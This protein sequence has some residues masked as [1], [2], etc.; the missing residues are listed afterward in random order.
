MER[1]TEGAPRGGAEG[2]GE[3]REIELQ[4]LGQKIL[5]REGFT[6][7]P[8]Y[9]ELLRRLQAA[10]IDANELWKGRC[11]KETALE[12][13]RILVDL[14][15]ETPS[16]ATTSETSEGGTEGSDSD[17]SESGEEDSDDSESDE[18]D[19]SE[20]TDGGED[21]EAR[22]QRRERARREREATVGRNKVILGLSAAALTAAAAAGAH[23]MMTDAQDATAPDPSGEQPG[24]TGEAVAGATDEEAEEAE[25]PED[26]R[27]Q[28]LREGADEIIQNIENGESVLADQLEQAKK[29]EK[30]ALIAEIKQAIE[31]GR[32]SHE[33]VFRGD[34]A[35]EDGTGPNKEKTSD[36]AFGKRVE[37]TTEEEVKDV[38]ER[39]I[40]NNTSVLAST[41]CGVS[42]DHRIDGAKGLSENELADKMESDIFFHYAVWRDC[43]D[44]MLTNPKVFDKTSLDGKYRNIFL[45]TIASDG[46]QI[47]DDTVTLKQCETTEKGTPALHIETQD[48]D[49]IELK[50]PCGLQRV[51]K[52]GT[53]EAE[54]IVEHVPELPTPP[55]ET[56]EPESDE[57]GEPPLDEKHNDTEENAFG[58][59]GAGDTWYDYDEDEDNTHYGDPTSKERETEEPKVVE[60]SYYESEPTLVS[61]DAAEADNSHSDDSYGASNDSYEAPEQTAANES[62]GAANE[63]ND[64]RPENS[65][66]D[67]ADAF[68]SGNF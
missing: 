65:Q 52:I 55:V 38:V 30:E 48:G 11:D 19:G 37:W 3:D 18:E 25:A 27:S 61:Q 5:N 64:S 1:H 50:L 54:K 24:I 44:K 13:Y 6:R 58:N 21:A 62:G 53:P 23:Y 32:F 31:D 43:T 66:N 56:P 47:T 59:G 34:Y 46:E 14:A 40:G 26:E 63:A 22:R 67:L 16:W 39:R 7:K 4:D 29:A 33:S 45:D 15:G 68:N 36:V 20:G 49:V 8:K 60:E 41:Y 9:S 35:N 10:G 42:D 51:G 17:D 2:S 12:A 57:P 28:E